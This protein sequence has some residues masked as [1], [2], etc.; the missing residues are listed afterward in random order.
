MFK[1][2][3]TYVNFNDEEVSKDFYFHMSK[4]EFVMLGVGAEAMD[5]RIKRM[6][7]TNDAKAV[8]DELDS[9]L[10]LAVG[11]KSEDGES[12]VKDQK[13]WNDF[14][15]SPAYDEFVMHLM[16]EP[17]RMVEFIN[18][19]IP[20]KMQKELRDHFAKQGSTP[21]VED[22]PAWVREDRDP[23]P[24]ELRNMTAAEMQAA[25]AKRLQQKQ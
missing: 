13:A 20:E 5:E 11:R 23:T 10:K 17:N 7:A 21:V 16:I 22:T 9:I 25:F 1:Q 3:I 4:P 15:F 19:L 12:F 8:L 24:Q 14:R 6:V 2:T 18:Q